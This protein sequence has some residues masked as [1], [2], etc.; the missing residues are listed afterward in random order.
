MHTSYILSWLIYGLVVIASGCYRYLSRP[1][2]E[3]GLAFGLAMGALAIAAAALLRSG[4]LR[5]GHA[6]GFCSLTLVTGWFLFE[7]LIKDGGNHEL[8]L[9]LVAGLSIV[10]AGIAVAHLR[11][12]PDNR[13]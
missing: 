11:K 10:Q 13:A 6:A 4:H 7:S 5:A 3:K 2:G 8:R 1:E 12:A 9:M